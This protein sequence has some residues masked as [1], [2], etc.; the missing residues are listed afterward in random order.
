MARYL[1]EMQLSPQ[2]YA[3]FIENPGDRA[4]AN[5]A[6]LESV[7]GKLIDYYFAIGSSIIYIIWET[8]DEISS[9]AVSMAVLAGGA[10][11]SSKCVGI[12]T[13]AETV[14]AMKMAGNAGYRAPSS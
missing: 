9:E 11:T 4:D 8:P 7:G 6:V 1:S 10:V 2:A 12:L 5:R 3:S 14:E 13:S